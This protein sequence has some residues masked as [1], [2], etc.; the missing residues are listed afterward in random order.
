MSFIDDVIEGYGY[1]VAPH[2]MQKR[3]E[4]KQQALIAT[5]MQQQM[6]RIVAPLK[7]QKLDPAH[8]ALIQML[9]N[10]GTSGVPGI[11]DKVPDMLYNMQDKSMVSIA[12]TQL[13]KNLHAMGYDLDTD[14]GRQVAL[15]ILTKPQSST[16][17][18][19][20]NEKPLDI[21][22]LDRLVGPDGKRIQP[23]LEE[24]R[25]PSKLKDK[26]GDISIGTANSVL[27]EVPTDITDAYRTNAQTLAELRNI[28]HDVERNSVVGDGL[29]AHRAFGWGNKPIGGDADKLDVIEQALGYTKEERNIF[30]DLRMRAGNS[31]GLR[32]HNLL[33]TAL[34][35]P[36]I[37]LSMGSML[38]PYSD[39]KDTVARK[40]KA[41]IDQ[42]ETYQR[43][44]NDTYSEKAGFEPI[45]A[46]DINNLT[47]LPPRK[48][49]DGSLS[50]FNPNTNLWEDQGKTS[51]NIVEQR[52]KEVRQRDDGS[53]VGITDKGE[54]VDLPEAEALRILKEGK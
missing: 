3:A 34:S 17:V 38:N 4:A 25:Q 24:A 10:A 28:L 13:M 14:A 42:L 50:V 26:Y 52:I 6:P 30:S 12:P 33:G 32:R 11:L 20:G 48:N 8:Q 1:A 23:T 21:A 37:E 5:L 36:E 53:Y 54:V 51:S 49:L 7:A 41:Q 35:R 16:S 2:Y 9:E 45:N 39:T 46:V 47:V 19:V 22:I 31:A 40:I 29:L 43:A 18:T 44:Y 15:S 27:K